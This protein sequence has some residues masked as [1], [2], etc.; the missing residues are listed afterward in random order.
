[1]PLKSPVKVLGIFST[2]ALVLGAES[3]QAPLVPRAR[4]LL[5]GDRGDSVQ[6]NEIPAPIE[7]LENVFPVWKYSTELQTSSFP[8]CNTIHATLTGLSV[9]AACYLRALCNQDMQTRGKNKRLPNP[10]WM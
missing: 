3:L 4:G 9:T 2:Q 1:M 10:A 5:C 6:I 8:C 7:P